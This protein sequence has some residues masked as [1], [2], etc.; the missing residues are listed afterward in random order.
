MIQ[1]GRRDRHYSFWP[2]FNVLSFATI[3]LRITLRTEGN[4]HSHEQ[5]L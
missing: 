3:T 4:E 2:L 1:S 5:D